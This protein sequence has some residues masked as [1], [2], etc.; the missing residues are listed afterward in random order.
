MDHAARL[1]GLTLLT[2]CSTLCACQKPPRSRGEAVTRMVQLQES[3]HYDD[4]VRVVEN[5]MN[6]HQNDTSQN[7]FLH[8]QIA[9]VFISKAVRHT[10]SSLPVTNHLATQH[11]TLSRHSTCMPQRNRKTKTQLSL[12]LEER[13]KFSEIY[14]KIM[15]VD[16][17]VRLEQ[18]LT[19]N[20]L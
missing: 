7:D 1:A 4:A 17:S 8:L 6:Q 13:M 10:T 3:G 15:N 2:I 14:R 16:S 12:G 9:M 18:H 20:C 19:S 5:W 11:H